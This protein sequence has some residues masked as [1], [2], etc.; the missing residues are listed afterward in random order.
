MERII[1]LLDVRATSLWVLTPDG[2][3][4]QLAG[5]LGFTD[6]F[7][8]EFAEGLPLDAPH[9][10]VRAVVSGEPVVHADASSS[11]VARPVREAY[12]RHGIPLGSLI[13]L[14]LQT[15]SGRIGGLTLA[16]EDARQFTDEDI[17]FD[18]SIA[19]AFATALE[20]ARLFEVERTLHA[21]EEERRSYAETLNRVNAIVHSSFDLDALLERV[22]VDAGSALNFGGAAIMFHEAGVWRIP[23][24]YG[25]EDEAAMAGIPDRDA[26]LAARIV[27]TPEIVVVDD[28]Q[29]DPRVNSENYRRFGVKGVIIVPLMARGDVESLLFLTLPQ[30]RDRF[31]EAQADFA[32]KLGSTISLA[33]EN[34]RLNEVERERLV[35]IETLHELTDLAVSSLDAQEVAQRAFTFMTE[36]LDV[37]YVNSFIHDSETDRLK[38]LAG[39]GGTPAYY[40]EVGEGFALD[41]P[42]D[43]ATVFAAGAPVVHESVTGEGAVGL[44][45]DLFERSSMPLETYAVLPLQSRTGT[46]G[47]LALAWAKQRLLAEGDLDFYMSLANE[48]ATALSNARLFEEVRSSNERVTEILTSMTDGFVAVD[49]DWRYVLVNPAAERMLHKTAPELL[50]NKLPEVFPDINGLPMYRKAMEQRVPVAFETYS[51]PTDAWVE[52]HVYPTGSGLSILAADISVRK[53]AEEA[54]RRQNAV[55]QGANRIFEAGL[56]TETGE[57]LGEACLQ[58]AQELTDSA[59]GFIGEINEQGKLSDLAMSDVAWAN[60]AMYDQTGHRRPPGEFAIHGIYG[61]VLVDGGNAFWTNQPGSHPDSVGLP[62]GHALVE[63]FLGVP[64]IAGGQVLGM[65]GL[66]NREGGFTDDQ[67]EIAQGIAPAIVE[68]IQRKRAEQRLSDA[69]MRLDAH[70]T[71]SPLAIVEFDS[72][73]RLTRWSVEAER[74]FGWTAS[75]VLGKAIGELHWVYEEDAELVERESAGLFTGATPRHLNTNR[76]YTKDGSVIWCEWYSSAF[77]DEEGHLVSVLSQILNITSRREAQE[78]RE[79]LLSEIETERGRLREIIEDIPVGVALVDANGAV[80]EVNEATDRIWAGDLPKAESV[81]GYAVYDGYHR[82]T[83]ARLKPDE[84]PAPRSHRHAASASKRWSTSS[85]ST[86]RRRRFGWT[87]YRSRTLRT[88][89]PGSSSSPRTSRSVSRPSDCERPWARSVPPQAQRST[90]TRSCTAFSPAQRRHW[91]WSRPQ[92]SCA[93]DATG[94]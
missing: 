59:F 79:T 7:A 43:V 19:T 18:T 35:R 50:G 73:F 31:T 46:V 25:I 67:L 66:A 90:P 83:G 32:K 6:G 33:V 86:A 94:S 5:N 84:W 57:A 42:F 3:R 70:I 23:Y 34:A 54:V 20:N 4:L 92:S 76:N 21:A 30:D 38:F 63:S 75:E 39:V 64:L 40:E 80:L 55:L 56:Q 47:V 17:D 48:L 77:Y 87:P 44:V 74:M 51:E 9:D 81:E 61:R 82:G 1:E 68:A 85:G 28:A 8:A 14:P 60:C 52:V 45:A 49:G 2:A 37:T 88:R 93:A 41:S 72:E 29:N 78:A 62:E 91:A 53:T 36:R 11:D 27:E 26:P 12:Q 15:P 71:N 16:W 58:V 65:I 22:T 69:T 24:R 13:A 89:S 10:V